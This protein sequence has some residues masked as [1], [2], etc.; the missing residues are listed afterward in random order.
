[1]DV[2]AGRAG[3]KTLALQY[4]CKAM[5]EGVDISDKNALLSSKI[6]VAQANGGWMLGHGE[7]G[8]GRSGH[9]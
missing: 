8:L 2:R 5:S 7:E 1:M 6:L 4:G 3:G 9:G